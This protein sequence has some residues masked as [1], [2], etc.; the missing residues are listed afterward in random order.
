MFKTGKDL[1]LGDTIYYV[2]DKNFTIVELMI[3][4]LEL[5]MGS[6]EYREIKSEWNGIRLSF[7]KQW[8]KKPEIINDGNKSVGFGIF[9][10][11]EDAIFSLNEYINKEVE[12]LNG[13][14]KRLN[15][16]KK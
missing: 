9:I 11:I 2:D 5:S 12:K 13:Q 4:G 6:C 8:E 7:G 15:G 16:Y 10:Y 3:E 14:I 1:K